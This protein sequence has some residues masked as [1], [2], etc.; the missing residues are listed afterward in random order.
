MRLFFAFLFSLLLA[1]PALAQNP[2]TVTNHA[3]AIGKGSGH[4]GYG[5]ALC[6][7]AQVPVG[8][9]AADPLCRTVSGDATLSAAGALTLATVNSNVGSFGSA[10]QCVAL[11][12]NGKGL[13]TA[14]SA[15]TCTPAIAS[16][17][18]L[19]TGVATALG[20]N[21]GSAGAPVLFDGA[22][23]TPS[24][25]DLTNATGTAA[26]LTAGHVTT[27]A[28]LTG[29]VTSVGNAATIAANA[30]TNAK[31]ATMAD[32]TIKSNVSGGVAAPSDNTISA[33]MDK[34]FGTAQGNIVYRGAS[35]WV[36]LPP[37]T[38]GQYLQTLGAAANPAWSTLSGGGNVLN[39]GTPTNGQFAVWTNANTIQGVSPAS[40]SDQQTGTSTTAAVTPS[41]QQSHDSALKATA[42][43][44]QSAGTYTLVAAPVSYGVASISKSAT[45]IVVVTLSTA[46]A[47]SNYKVLC[48]A[49]QTTPVT[50]QEAGGNRTTTTFEIRIQSVGTTPALTDSG[51]SCDIS[52]RQ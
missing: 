51:F 41:Q 21:I 47:S 25:I 33:V 7:S 24:S 27:N 52:G 2:G 6:T 22:G 49:N 48:M 39:T 35:G 18:G 43:I 20:T 17:T 29:D 46:M 16:V 45:G 1:A 13:I 34:L 23:G 44:T 31:M 26:G 15:V 32:G 37:G 28:N 14:A 11:T 36:S 30:V 4:A 42:V 40:K 12:T 50:V 9:S 19:G 8:Q 5:S 10:T 3:F 38:S